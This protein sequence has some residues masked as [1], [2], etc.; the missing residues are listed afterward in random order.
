M[1]VG[2]DGHKAKDLSPW[3]TY[4]MANVKHDNSMSYV[5]IFM[6]L[7]ICIIIIQNY[8]IIII[9]SFINIFPYS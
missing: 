1:A 6:Y 5:D 4:E 7:L 9:I 8:I 2:P 3:S